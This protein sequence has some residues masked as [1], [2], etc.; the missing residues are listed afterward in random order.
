LGWR[1]DKKTN[2]LLITGKR[3]AQAS[4][5]ELCVTAHDGATPLDNVSNATLLGLEIDCKL[6][7]SE[8]VEKV[9]KK[10]ASRIAILRKIRS[11]LPLAQRKQ[12]YK[13]LILPIINY[14]SAVWSECDHKYVNRIF[15]LQ[16]RAA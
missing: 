4:S 5:E 13:A 2:V 3:F 6:S 7:F 11:L 14:G 12:Y 16:K 15:R 9:C 8:H 10:V 1:W